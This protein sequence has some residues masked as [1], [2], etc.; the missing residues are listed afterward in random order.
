M[1]II[2]KTKLALAVALASS[3]L[4]YGQ[5]NPANGEQVLEEILITGS[6]I[7]RKD[8]SSSSPVATLSVETIEGFGAVTVEETLNALP[9]FIAG[10]SSSTIAIGGGGGATLNLRAL[11]PTRNLVLMDQRR[12]PTSTPFGEVDVN[13]LPSVMLK[14]VEVLT[15]GASSVYG[16]EAISGVVNFQSADYFNGVKYNLEYGTS[17]EDDGAKTDLSVLFGA[18]SDDGR[19]RGLL[20]LGRSDRDEVRGADRGWRL[21]AVKSSFIGQGAFRD[22]AA[23][24]VDVGAINAL[25]TGYGTPGNIVSGD[26]LAFNDDGSLFTQGFSNEFL[27]YVGPSGD[28]TLFALTPGGLRQPVGRQGDIVKPLERQSLFTKGEY[29]LTETMTVYAQYLYSNAETAG[30]VSRNL[31]LFAPEGAQVSVPVTNPFIPA[32]LA[33]LLATR[34][35]PTA[36]FGI[37]KRFL[38]LPDRT[39]VEEFETTQFVF[40]LKGELGFRDWTYDVYTTKDSVNATENIPD[41]ALS[42]RVADLLFAADGG[43]SICAGGYNPFGLANELSLSAECQEYIAPG[44]ISSLETDRSLFEATVTGTLF[45]IPAGAVQFSLTAG[46]REEKL[47][48]QPDVSVQSN[49]AFGL[50]P[51]VRT[52]GET[53]TTEIGGE[54]LVPI[55]EAINLTAGYRISDQD[56]SGDADS[57]SFG[58]EWAATDSLFVR[59]SLQQAVRAPNVGELFT[60]PFGSEVTVGDPLAGGAGDPCDSRNNPSAATLAICSAQGASAVALPGFQHDTTSLPLVI[61]GNQQLEAET[62]DTFTVGVVWQPELDNQELSLTLDYWQIEIEDV[63]K[64]I[65]G[66]DVLSRCYNNGQNP[67]LDPN[68]TFCQLISR[69]TTGSVTEVRSTFLNLAA[70]ETS[71]VDLQINH[72]IEM[73]PGTLRTNAFF[74]FLTS[75]DTQGFPGENFV[76]E[77]G[78]INGIANRSSDNNFHPELKFT[79]SPSYEWDKYSVGLRWRY[80]DAVDD[81]TGSNDDISSYSLI[82]LNARY[83]V[84]DSVSLKFSVSNLS[85]KEPPEYGGEDL[86][87][88]GSYDVV[89]RFFSIG[90]QGS[91]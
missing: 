61:S 88:F 16:S 87:R 69:D 22:N 31:T 1:K 78:T 70:L 30:T 43:A 6:R 8:Y 60:A 34:A 66:S 3:S 89:G 73:G 40:G 68:N 27:N 47:S 2:S 14:N 64:P 42:S 46:Y 5:S 39:H 50:P 21:N 19:S 10:N 74:G 37:S 41:L 23:N 56:V 13:I 51:T 12:L 57:W 62:A 75:Y 84:S 25:F 67:G 80:T 86:T 76:D 11:G 9:Q 65:E 72:A 45:E 48:T 17:S 81:L 20:A 35:D 91:F 18:E 36:D 49:D 4:S 24:P 58:L 55:T 26:R 32:D 7:V 79:L 29:D 59:G 54:L 71:G 52:R 63:I 28:D 38:S 90:V 53:E 44:S 83:D 82:D 33:A 15:G 85:D 77:A